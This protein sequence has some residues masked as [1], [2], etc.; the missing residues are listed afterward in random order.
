MAPDTWPGIE[1][2]AHHQQSHSWDRHRRVAPNLSSFLGIVIWPAVNSIQH[3]RFK[4]AFYARTGISPMSLHQTAVFQTWVTANMLHQPASQ[5]QLELSHAPDLTGSK[6]IPVNYR[7]LWRLPLKQLLEHENSIV[8]KGELTFKHWEEKLKTAGVS[9]DSH[10]RTV[11]LKCSKLAITLHHAWTVDSHPYI[12]IKNVWNPTTQVS[13][14]RLSIY[15][16]LNLLLA[17]KSGRTL[18]RSCSREVFQQWH[19]VRKQV[20]LMSTI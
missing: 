15:S 16:A 1:I 12:P 9:L 5:Q 14:T 18:L 10:A 7:Q 20:Q 8:H 4:Q 2:D 17:V 3:H 6:T 11:P 13:L 19:W